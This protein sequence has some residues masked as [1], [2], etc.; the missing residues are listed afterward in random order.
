IWDE[1]LA[2]T[3]VFSAKTIRLT[4]TLAEHLD[5]P[6][7]GEGLRPY[8]LSGAPG[9]IGLLTHPGLVSGMTNAD[10][11]AIVARGLFLQTQLFCQE[12]PSPPAALQ[13]AIDD[14]VE[15]LPETAS[16]RMIAETRLEREQCGNCHGG[17]DPLAYGL[18]QFDYQG[19]F[20]SEDEHGN[21]LATNGWIPARVRTEGDDLSYD[22]V[23]EL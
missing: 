5:L 17:F 23:E 11:G 16:D 3:E 2:P 12:T 19:R 13:D 20:R 10:G 9:R 8:D 15:E 21:P 6:S 14:F 7:Q 22:D 4:P 1:S 18:E